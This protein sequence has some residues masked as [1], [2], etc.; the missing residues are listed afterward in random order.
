MKKLLILILIIFNPSLAFADDIESVLNKVYTKGSKVAEGYIQNLL[1]GQGDTEVS[2][3]AKNENKPT[4]TIMVVRPLSI[5][6]RDLT[7]YQAQL[8]SFHVLGDTRQSMNFGIGKRF[9]S[10]DGSSFLGINSFLDYDIESNNRIG[11]GVEFRASNFD[12][13]ANYYK[14][15]L[16]GANQ[17]GTDSERVLDGYD[18]KV[19]GQVP[20]APW[21]DI[22]YTS[23]Q[24]DAKRA[25]TDSDGDVYSTSLNLSNNLT[26]EAGY[27]DNNI[28]DS[29]DYFKLTY[30]SGG[31]NRPI[32]SDG[33]STE[34]FLNSD[35]REEMLS[36]VER[37]NII[38]LEVESTG[39]VITNGNSS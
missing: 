2:I 35:V 26:L 3:S 19:E 10:E 1:D 13:Y 20:Y 15:G 8:N 37:S 17:V 39:V 5:N 34:A 11:L 9:L 22:S 12:V 29:M 38:T 36:K 16:G 14:G 21:A 30:L 25:S 32:I 23:Y 28:N 6:E 27:D 18:I 7:F 4:G 31:K 33:F 24:W